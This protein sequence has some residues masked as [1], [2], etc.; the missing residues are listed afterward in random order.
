MNRFRS[1]K[2]LRPWRA[3]LPAVLL[4]A[5]AGCGPGQGEISGVVRYN[6]EPLPSGTIQF[7][8]PDGIPPA[9]KIRPDG[10]YSVQAPAGDAKVVVSCVDEARLNSFL[11]GLAAG[12][13][14]AAP[15]TPA[16]GDFSRIPQ[17]YADWNASG[18]TAR[19]R[20]GK[21]TQDFDLTSD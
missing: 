13:G 17:R 15:P 21:I 19:V 18:L 7:L 4:C 12:H 6:G 3:A 11:G 9:A 8:G 2:R 14:R 1:L 16:A 20:S 10:T 5:A